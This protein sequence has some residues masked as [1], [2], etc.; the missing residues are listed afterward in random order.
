MRSAPDGKY[1]ARVVADGGYGPVDNEAAAAVPVP[2]A[3]AAAAGGG[4]IEAGAVGEG[5]RGFAA[6]PADGARV[7]DPPAADAV[8]DVTGSVAAPSA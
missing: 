2:A 5:V 8:V 7:D 6:V 4:N 3:A 1:E